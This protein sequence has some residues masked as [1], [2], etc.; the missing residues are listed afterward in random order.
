MN[1]PIA[2]L[3]SR[4]PSGLLFGV[5][6]PIL[7]DEVH[8]WLF[9][10]TDDVIPVLFADGTPAELIEWPLERSDVKEALGTEQKTGYRF[11]VA[12]L[13]KGASIELYALHNQKLS[14]VAQRT[15]EAAVL[16]SEPMQQLAIAEQ[17]ARREGAVAITCWDAAHNPIGRAKVLYDVCESKRPT[18]IFSYLFDEFGGK[19]WAPLR[20]SEVVIVTIPWKERR[21][22]HNLIRQMGITFST[23]WLCKPRYPTFE[24]ASVVS[25]PD[26]KLILDLDDN[27]EHFAMSPAARTKPYG[28]A[29]LGIAR[30]LTHRV[31]A[32]TVASSSLQNDFGGRVVRHARPYFTESTPRELEGRNLSVGFIG[33]V[34]KHKN[35][36]TAARALKIFTWI[37]KVDVTFCVYGDVQPA[38]YARE[39]EAEGVIIQ[40]TVKSAELQRELSR[41]DVILTGYPSSETDDTSVT[42]YQ[43]SS[44]IG[45]ALSVRRPVLVPEGPSVED[46]QYVPGVFLFN[47]ASF[48]SKLAAAMSYKETISLPREFTFEGAYSEFAAAEKIAA[49]S[50]RAADAFAGLRDVLPTGHQV[51][52]PTLLLIWKQHDAALYG[53][54]VDQIARSYKKTHPH[55]KVIV[56]ELLHDQSL[57]DLKL[58]IANAYSDAEM[59]VSASSWKISSEPPSNGAVEYKMLSFKSSSDLPYVF[60]D[61]LAKHH[62]TPKN[63]TVILFPYTHLLEFIL[64]TLSP[65]K[66]IVDVVDN[67]LSWSSRESSSRVCAQYALLGRT[68]DH[69][70]FNS[71]NTQ[72]FFK[73]AFCA[74]SQVPTSLVENWYRLPES[75][76]CSRNLEDPKFSAVYTGNMNDRVDWALVEHVSDELGGA[77]VVHLAGAAHRGGDGFFRV[78]GRQN[79]VYHGP[80]TELEALQLLAQSH[81]ALMPHAHDNVSAFMNPLKVHMY[82]ALGLQIISTSVPGIA[83]DLST[84]KLC[85]SAGQ[86]AEAV[87]TALKSWQSNPEAWS[88]QRKTINAFIDDESNDEAMYLKIIT[89]LMSR[90]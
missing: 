82:A 54:R 6:D 56:L 16:Q 59:I 18:V 19:I 51:D 43:I 68:A 24:L 28:Q 48:F 71:E 84:L 17:Y 39:L 90:S 41:L 30:E 35:L 31:E 49:H 32:R 74:G 57:T 60:R 34:R 22:Y 52:P 69:L 10:A 45:D 8:G 50:L 38:E 83:P 78:L 73:K 58:S 13:R 88:S 65:Y 9:S 29:R 46:L 5:I 64:P 7:G 23:V 86:F 47:E 85:Y 61:F 44:K 15:S 77:G 4:T 67:Q 33:T 36:L 27:E 55:H 66:K 1:A 26:A 79:V 25:A 40:G 89:E 76:D 20:D 70:V 3:E 21:T 81:V 63:T 42:R 2:T 80:L 75:F 87:A 62:V 14:L 53:R 37:T 12:G 72:E 11:R